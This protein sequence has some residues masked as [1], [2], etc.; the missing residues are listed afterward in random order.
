MRKIEFK[1]IVKVLFL[2]LYTHLIIRDVQNM[3]ESV[4]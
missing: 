1:L 2:V 3:I 4:Y